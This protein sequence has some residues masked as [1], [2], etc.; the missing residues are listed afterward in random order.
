M[1]S[2]KA[3]MPTTVAVAWPCQGT[4]VQ[5]PCQSWTASYSEVASFL[6]ITENSNSRGDKMHTYILVQS[7]ENEEGS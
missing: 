7:E 6:L 2:S 3:V 4:T 5:C 1:C